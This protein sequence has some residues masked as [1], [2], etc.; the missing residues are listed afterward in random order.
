MN[1]CG[2]IVF[3]SG[4]HG[5]P[6]SEI[7]LYDNGVLEALTDDNISDALANLAEDGTIAWTRNAD[8]FC[9]G[10]IVMRRLGG[11]FVIGDG[12][13]PAV[14]SH[15]HIASGRTEE[16]SEIRLHLYNGLSNTPLT[17][18]CLSHQSPQY[19]DDS[20]LAWIRYDF[21]QFPWIS[22]VLIMTSSRPINIPTT[23]STPQLLTQNQ[24]GELA[25]ANGQSIEIWR[26][27]SVSTFGPGHVPA[28]NDLGDVAYSRKPSPQSYWQ[29]RAFLDGITYQITDAPYESSRADINN[30][31]EVVWRWFMPALEPSGVRLMRR[32]R[33]GDLDFDDDVD[34]HD[35]ARGVV[36]VTGPWDTPRLCDC[37]FIDLDHNRTVDLK[38]FAAFQ[39]AFDVPR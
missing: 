16:C 10:E 25:W 18:D 36:C 27:G 5:E 30:Y 8:G 20:Q 13:S 26:N 14:N 38:D 34:L 1:N 9:G 15:G 21:T 4:L 31:R 2:E 33:T 22:D 28:I 23:Q 37:R 24:L 35:H 3:S 7:L 6:N 19:N 17:F 12:C 39:E 32:I 11:L 29:I